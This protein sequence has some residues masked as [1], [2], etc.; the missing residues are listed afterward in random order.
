MPDYKNQLDR[1]EQLLNEHSIPKEVWIGTDSIADRVDWLIRNRRLY[2]KASESRLEMLDALV[3][4]A[5][6]ALKYVETVNYFEQARSGNL[7][8]EAACLAG[9]LNEALAKAKPLSTALLNL[10]KAENEKAI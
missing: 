7:N 2:K 4:A 9:L 3:F 1:I 6:E 5:N 8:E 10:R